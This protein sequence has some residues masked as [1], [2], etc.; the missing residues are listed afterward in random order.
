MTGARAAGPLAIVAGCALEPPP[1]VPLP[2]GDAAVFVAQA[3]PVL[4]RHCADA[5]CHADADRAFALY[6]PGRRRA[7]PERQFLHEPLT[8]DEL[9]ANARAVAGFALDPLHAGTAID[10]CLVLCKPLAVTAGGCGHVPGPL[11]TGADERD[12]QALRAYLATLR[13]PEDP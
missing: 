5:S 12:Y 4:E 6:S 11:F 2:V 13:L 9:A 1:P 3:E 10:A 7:D 8:A